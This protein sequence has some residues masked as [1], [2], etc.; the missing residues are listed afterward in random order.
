MSIAPPLTGAAWPASIHDAADRGRHPEHPLARS[1]LR[2]LV[3]EVLVGWERE[4]RLFTALGGEGQW[5]V[6]LV[7]TDPE[8]PFGRW[9]CAPAS[10]L[11]LRCLLAGRAH[12]ADLFRHSLTGCVVDIRIGD[13][14]YVT[15]LELDGSFLTEEDLPS[16]A[17][18]IAGTA[19]GQ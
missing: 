4:P 13:D 6:M 16:A 7:R 9:L 5:L 17:N 19:C 11:A 1:S 18:L 14:G 12:P 10:P 2:L 3:D 15:E 8:P